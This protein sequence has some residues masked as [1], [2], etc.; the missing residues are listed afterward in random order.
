VV[1]MLLEG[2]SCLALES[3]AKIVWSLA[4]QVP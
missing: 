2:M 1:E 4:V 3:A